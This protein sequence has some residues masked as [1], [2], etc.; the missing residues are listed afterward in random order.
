MARPT[1]QPLVMLPGLLCDATL[2][3]AQIDGLADIAAVNVPDLTI[4]D[5]V[6]AMAAR[7]LAAAPPRFALAALS[8]G[9]YVAFEILRQAPERVERIALLS[10]SAA[11]DSPER[12]AQRHAAMDSLKYGR[13]AGVTERMLPQLIAE[14]RLHAPVAERI[15]A[16]AERVGPDAY[17][18]QQRAILDRPDSRAMLPS[19]ALPTTIIVGAEDVLTPPSE[20]RAMHEAIPGAALHILPGCG[21][22]TAMEEPDMVTQLLREWLAK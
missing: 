14:T 8:M 1:L 22:M 12:S 18:R 10:T 7:A 13:F 20:A 5:S 15:M 6:G 17:L 11:A 16:M 9:G 3:R 2:W 19:L 21:H 4:D